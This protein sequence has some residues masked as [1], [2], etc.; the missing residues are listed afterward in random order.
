MLLEENQIYTNAQ[1]A[2]W[3]GIKEESFKHSK[4]KKLEYLKN[5]AEFEEVSGKIKILE[6]YQAEYMNPRDKK[7]NDT[8]YR[9]DI[10]AVLSQDPIQYKKTCANRIQKAEKSKTKILNHK[11]KTAYN[12]VCENIEKVADKDKNV[13]CKRFYGED[14]DFIP[15][16]EEQLKFWKVL[17]QKNMNSEEVAEAQSLYKNGEIS[18]TEF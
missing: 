4:A 3:F 7:R 8:L 9:K 10:I 11:F 18:L 5:F 6:V 13:W 15:L 1:M 12:Y 17:I 2:E 14:K 16:T